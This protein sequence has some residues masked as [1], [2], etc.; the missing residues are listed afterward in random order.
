M[1]TLPFSWLSLSSPSSFSMSAMVTL[2]AQEMVQPHCPPRGPGPG[3][4]ERRPSR[5]EE[6]AEALF[7]IPSSQLC[8]KASK[9]LP[10]VEAG[11]QCA[12]LKASRGEAWPCAETSRNQQM[13]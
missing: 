3:M 13:L 6:A 12:R 2:C 9:A 7:H 10:A 1:L 5:M 4:A 11:A 8:P